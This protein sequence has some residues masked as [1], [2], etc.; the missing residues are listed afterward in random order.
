MSRRL[1]GLLIRAVLL[2]SFLGLAI[3]PAGIEAL[4][5][6]D[7]PMDVLLHTPPPI[8]VFLVDNSGS[9]D[10]ELM[11]PE[12]YGIHDGACYIFPD[13][14]YTPDIDHVHGG[15]YALS[16]SF[17]RAWKTQWSGHNRIY[18][19]PRTV[20]TPWPSTQQHAF[21]PANPNHP[22]S[23][24]ATDNGVKPRLNLAETF[25]VVTGISGEILVA[26]AHYFVR[27]GT[28]SGQQ[29]YLVTWEDA[30]QDG[31]LDLGGVP[32]DDRRQ[33][34]RL[35]DDGDDQVEDGELTLV[36]DEDE[37]NSIRP[38]VF[39]S[40]GGF[41]RYATDL[42]ELQ[43]FANW[44]SYHRRR[45][46]AA[47]AAV[48]G[49][50]DQA[51]SVYIGLYAVN[52][53]PRMSVRPMRLTTQSGQNNGAGEGQGEALLNA[54][55]AMHVG[56]DSPLRNALD[57]VGRYM[58][59]N[60]SSDM[61]PSPYLEASDGGGCQRASVVVVSDGF[62][63]GSA[64]AVGNADGDDGR[65]YADAWSHTLADVAMHYYELDLASD[66][67]DDLHPID[68]DAGPH[69]HLTTYALSFGMPGVAADSQD[70]EIYKADT[71]RLQEGLLNVSWPRPCDDAG[72]EL[73]DATSQVQEC[74]PAVVS[75]NLWHAAVNGRGDYWN[76]GS[77]KSL[78]NAIYGLLAPTDAFVSS[79][80]VAVNS[81]IY[82]EQSV[83]Y[84]ATY[85]TADWRGEVS[86]LSRGGSGPVLWRA[87]EGLQPDGE[88]WDRRRIVTYGG[89]WRQPQGVA[90]RYD[91]LSS[92]QMTALGSDL[93]A[94]STAEK[95]ARQLVQYI[96]GRAID[97]YRSRS[98]LL[99]DIVHA[100]PVLFGETLFVGGNDGMLHAFD[101]QTGGERFAYV[102]NLVLANLK[103]LAAP[104]Y[105]D[106]HRYYVDGPVF[107]GEVLVG[108]HE[109]KTYLVG[110]LG[111]GGKGY[112]AI[113][114]GHRKRPE[115][116]DG[117]GG[118]RW[119]SH[120]DQ[121]GSGSSEGEIAQSIQW[122]Y[123]RPASDLDGDAKTGEAN[124]GDPDMGYSYSQAYCVNGNAPA[125]TYRPVVIFGNGYNSATQ[126]ALLYILDAQSGELIRKIDTGRR[127]DNGLSTPALIDVNLDR[128]VDYVYAGDLRGNLWKFD[129]SA[130]D[131]SR[132]GV[133]YGEDR[134][135]DGV[136]DAADG[137]LPAPLFQAEGQPITSRPDVM[138]MHSACAS[139]APGFLVV[140]GT[141][142]YLGATDRLDQ[143][144]QSI[145]GLWDYGDDGDDSEYLGT[146][147][148]RQS[149]QLSSGFYLLPQE[150]KA[151][152]AYEDDDQGELETVEV[153][154]V[155]VED[156]ED[157]D[158]SSLNNGNH[159]QH[160][161]PEKYVGWFHD[162]PSATEVD[163]ASAER[164]TADI[165]I[166]G[167]K[168]IVISYLP[169]S[170]LCRSGGDSRLYI[171]TA[172]AGAITEDDS[173]D[174]LRP[175]KF[176]G[177]LSDHSVV[178]KE[179]SQPR[180]DK[181]VTNDQA[182]N[183]LAIDF[184][185][186]RWGKVSWRQNIDD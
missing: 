162:F 100:T 179:L 33:Y 91:E 21:G 116:N 29:T 36:T 110:G 46:S 180:L 139:Q 20:Y 142:R 69:Q 70:V 93:I 166:R 27:S 103:S 12:S 124:G 101:T 153:E 66:L 6:S 34:Y 2:V 58:R 32:S 74:L 15:G 83:I 174:P 60:I 170:T 151:Q 51:Q 40:A 155:L 97:G 140:F 104:N 79:S 186:E 31:S 144:Q 89:Y 7:G 130:E 55:Y 152:E 1:R 123:P 48:A 13:A 107:A 182:G 81:G 159:S 64:P 90:F 37:K 164:V 137:D 57:Q 141:G 45:V 98:S 28:G 156:H 9:M 84:Q 129:L 47:K 122:E 163:S 99:G 161:D 42:E 56:G 119:L 26:N 16:E 52:D 68:C 112:F 43:N 94:S 149:G 134:D 17:R 165:V 75:D 109:R 11:T 62:G 86:A 108:Q 105:P 131:P 95:Q 147:I 72:P 127:E 128:R 87:S 22:L 77:Q 61:G 111:K 185:G 113:L 171:L 118:Y 59:R 150:I 67:P 10:C 169:D 136:I 73:P 96:R 160:D 133:A 78:D 117:F 65:P 175:M 154:Y 168:A 24:P 41:E 173:G 158:Q 18:Y 30:D 25:Y 19:S 80:G 3:L 115:T 38:S 14:A 102:P 184:L 183:I 88:I 54:L 135:G 138:I 146:M 106:H 120:V 121:I 82:S 5:I 125:E 176:N 148:S 4:E 157:G 63:N 145:Y 114:A 126:A 172:C 71:C 49:L 39:N 181:L 53:N 23:N 76:I 167:G 92:A 35:M 178:L 132:W 50:I 8:V 85:H 177:K 143:S 44:F